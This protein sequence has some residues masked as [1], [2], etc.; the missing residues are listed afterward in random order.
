M[1][2]ASTP[3]LATGT[4]TAS[5]P[6][7]SVHCHRQGGFTFLEIL[8]VIVIIG[9]TITFASL[10]LSS[11][12]ADERLAT[13]ADRLHALLSL[14]AEEAIV[15]GEQI[16]LL[17]AADGYAFYHLE[18]NQWT[19]YEQGA[20]HERILP[21]GMRLYLADDGREAVQIPVHK[22]SSKNPDKDKKVITPQILL[23]S[24]GEIT[25]FVLQLRAEHIKAYYQAEG[26]ITGEIKMQRVGEKPA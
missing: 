17:L 14:A 3:T 22:N 12:A 5:A 16:G 11:R 20:L 1:A 2:R 21:E 23:L 4:L 7:R 15:Q 13:E 26:N 18:E 10:A 24:S 25:P 19:A 9:I 6:S 8:A